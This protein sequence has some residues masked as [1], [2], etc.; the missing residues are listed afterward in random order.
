MERVSNGR[1]DGDGMVYL[2]NERFLEATPHAPHNGSVH[3]RGLFSPEFVGIV[4]QRL[5]VAPGGSGCRPQGVEVMGVICIG[6]HPF[7]YTSDFVPK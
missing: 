5:A 3:E 7:E 1:T 4:Y 2:W 6:H